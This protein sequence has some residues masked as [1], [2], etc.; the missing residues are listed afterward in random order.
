MNQQHRL[1][2]PTPTHR[3]PQPTNVHQLEHESFLPAPER[4]L[5]RPEATPGS[6]AVEPVPGPDGAGGSIGVH[7]DAACPI[8]DTVPNRTTRLTSQRAGVDS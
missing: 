8:L 7:V 3:A 6:C 1:T 2:L 4:P 5:A